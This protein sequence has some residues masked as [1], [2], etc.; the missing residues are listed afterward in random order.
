ML[1]KIL[2]SYTII[3]EHL[4][5]RREADR[6]MEFI[7]NDTGRPGYVL[8]A[9]QMGKTNLLL[10]AKEQLIGPDDACVYADFSN[11][12]RTAREC[13]RYIIDLAIETNPEKLHFLTDSIKKSRDERDEVDHVE[14]L[15]ELRAILRVIKGKLIILIDEV[16]AMTTVSF[17][18]IIFKQIRSVYFSRTNYPVLHKLNYILSGVGEPAKLIKDPKISPFNI[19]QEIFLGDFSYLEYQEFL[20]KAK[21]NLSNEVVERVYYWTN[22]NPR[23]TYEVCSAVED[24]LQIDS[25]IDA[26]VVDKIVNMMYLTTYDRVPLDNIRS[27]VQSDQEMASAVKSLK[28]RELASI[29]MTQRRQLYL[30]GIVG[31]NFENDKINIKNRIIDHALSNEWLSEIVE[32]DSSL[33][34]LASIAFANKDYDG[35]IL[36]LEEN[37]D[38]YTGFDFVILQQTII[39]AY[40]NKQKFDSIVEHFDKRG[41]EVSSA[42][43]KGALR[44][45]L[46]SLFLY[47]SSL[48]EHA[49]YNKSFSILTVIVGF[50]LYNIHYFNSLLGIAN[51]VS[52][53]DLLDEKNQS[54]I[55][56]NDFNQISIY[57][58]IVH[59]IGSVKY[60][61]S[62]DEYD[63]VT[64]AVY[65]NMGLY[66]QSINETQLAFSNFNEAFSR[67]GN[68]LQPFV[69]YHMATTS[70]NPNESN[71]LYLDTINAIV[72][73]KLNLRDYFGN[74]AIYFGYVNAFDLIKRCLEF[75]REYAFVLIKYIYDEEMKM[76]KLVGANYGNQKATEE[77]VAR[78]EIFITSFD[79]FSSSLSKEQMK[80]GYYI[81]KESS[82]TSVNRGKPFVDAMLKYDYLNELDSIDLSHISVVV[83]NAIQNDEV[84]FSQDV[85]KYMRDHYFNKKGRSISEITLMDYYEMEIMKKRSKSFEVFDKAKSILTA[86]K[87]FDFDSN[88]S[89]FVDKKNVDNIRNV[90]FKTY[91]ELMPRFSTD[92]DSKLGERNRRVTVL[93]KNGLKLT[94]KF[95]RFEKDLI[96][97]KCKVIG[98]D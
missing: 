89:I 10:N 18:D 11:S 15:Q 88:E 13:F 94:D 93:Y 12:F 65:C 29:T 50:K 35:V 46:E 8:V 96:K 24:V 69:L 22:G 14:H 5:V 67:A 73:N 51:L 80:F 38:K 60:I 85:V 21:L 58:R 23:M 72:N 86:L 33:V 55:E 40:F 32:E 64:F 47:A 71:S 75:S 45:K 30:A 87:G 3:P 83:H 42:L 82:V 59:E 98:N 43:P 9:R 37:I 57:S 92:I 7:I 91:T 76:P 49:E 56:E 66:Y 26:E 61:L 81:F 25:A 52:S 19:G 70:Q 27:M 36:L 54:S 34:E 90:A 2:R 77:I 79:E 31:A 44:L 39:S 48:I 95:K 97:G 1:N 41:A 20:K 17:S 53:I 62:K 84:D 78:D 68:A 63:L 28:N 74:T 16:D 4:Y 6:L